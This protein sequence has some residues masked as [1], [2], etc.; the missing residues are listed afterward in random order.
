MLI[1]TPRSAFSK[2]FY[3]HGGQDLRGDVEYR[4]ATEQGSLNWGGET[5]GVRKHGPGSGY[6][7]LEHRGEILADAQKPS[8][9]RRR[10]LVETADLKLEL[11]PRS[12]YRRAF[13]VLQGG[14]VIGTIEPDHAF[15]RRATLEFGEDIAEHIQLFCFWLVALMW[16]RSRGNK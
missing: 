3:V 7:T 16:R 9:F 6:W 11:C 13:D 14:R 15:T 5:F 10:L 2:Q 1:C 4:L 12:A 8:A